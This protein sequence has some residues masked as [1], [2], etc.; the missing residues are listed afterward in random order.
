MKLK[1]DW[2]RHGITEYNVQ[3]QSSILGYL[4]Q[5]W[6]DENL[7]ESGI[8]QTKSQKI[9]EYDLI[10]TSLLPR[11]IQSGL[12]LL[13]NS[14][15]DTIYPCPYLNEIRPW[16]AGGSD[17]V[18]KPKED[19]RSLKQSIR[20]FKKKLDLKK[21]SSIN[22]KFVE[23]Y[24]EDW[25]FINLYN[26]DEFY[27]FLFDIARKENAKKILVV[28][29]SWY[30]YKNFEFPKFGFTRIPNDSLWSETIKENRIREKFKVVHYE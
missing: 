25:D 4:S 3:A 27:N 1:V 28:A 18:N 20:K 23:N 17:I 7:H 12:L 5:G 8:K 29:H 2:I 24:K 13:E 30:M 14:S 15:N 22:Y 10:L 21:K 26:I 16:W 6:S 11:S 19:L 9:R